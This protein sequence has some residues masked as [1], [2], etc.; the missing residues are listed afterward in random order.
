MQRVKEIV[1]KQIRWAL[2]NLAELES[3]QYEQLEYFRY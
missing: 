3:E 2:R 1:M